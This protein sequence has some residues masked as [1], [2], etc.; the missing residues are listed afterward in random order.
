MNNA[1]TPTAPAGTPLL[2]TRAKR[3][4]SLQIPADMALYAALVGKTPEIDPTLANP[5]TAAV[6]ARRENPWSP[7]VLSVYLREICREKAM[8]MN[9]PELAAWIRRQSEMAKKRLTETQNR[10][11]AARRDRAA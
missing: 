11:L 10:V 4:V 9:K 2:A 8:R 5:K 7:S 1:S 3:P 6:E